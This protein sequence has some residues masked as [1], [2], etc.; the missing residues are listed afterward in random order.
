MPAAVATALQVHEVLGVVT[1]T[2]LQQVIQS[3]LLIP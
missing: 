3:D 2:N 1:E